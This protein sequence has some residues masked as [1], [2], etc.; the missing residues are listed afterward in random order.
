MI[1]D[2]L[3]GDIRAQYDKVV[4]ND[5]MGID[6]ILDETEFNIYKGNHEKA[7][8]IIEPLVRKLGEGDR[9]KDDEVSEYRNFDE[10]FETFLYMIRTKTNKTIRNPKVPFTEHV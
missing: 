7:M 6:A 1:Y 9:F 10:L 4:N 8:S 2:L 5:A 3:P